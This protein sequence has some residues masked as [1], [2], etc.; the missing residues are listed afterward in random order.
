MATTD[1]P[2]RVSTASVSVD[3]VIQRVGKDIVL[4]LPLGL[5][6]PIHFTNAL[7]QRAMKD[8]SIQLHIVTALSLVPPK[9]KKGAATELEYRFKL[10]IIERLYADI[11]ELDYAR[12]VRDRALPDNVKVS[13]FFFQAGDFLHH[14]EQ[15]RRYICTNYTHALRDLQA[16]GINVV[17]QLLASPEAH[18]SEE[19]PAQFSL[20]CNPDLS[21]DLFRALRA[22]ETK[23]NPV[24]LVGEVNQ[25]LPFFGHD[26]ALPAETF[27]VVLQQPE[28]DYALFPVPQNAISAQDHLI[29]FYASTLLKDG[30]TLQVGIGSLGSALIYST[31]LRHQD[32]HAWQTLF[33]A[34]RVDERFPVVGRIGGNKPFKNGLYGCSEMMVDGFIYLLEAGILKRKVYP[35]AVLQEQINAGELEPQSDDDPRLQQ[36]V[37]MHGGFFLGP[38]RFYEKLNEL[39]DEQRQLICMTSVNFINNLTNHRF[40]DQRLKVA[41]RQHSRFINS[42][43]QCTLNGAVVS[44]GLED[45]RVL[46]GVGGQYN[47]VS[48]AHELPGARS[49][50]TLRATRT[51]HGKTRSTI[52]FSYGH[53]TIPRHLRDIVIT[54]YGIAD[55]RGKNDEQVYLELIR[56]ADSRFQSDLLKQAQDAGKVAPDFRLPQDWQNNTP[57][58]VQGA[59]QALQTKGLFPAFPYGTELNDTERTLKPA[60]EY[61]QSLAATIRG[62]LKLLGQALLAGGARPADR[63]LLQRMQLE[64]PRSPASWFARRLLR[65]A[66]KHTGH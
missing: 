10:P 63:V 4:G 26:A 45:G 3:E 54:E 61:V 7:Y 31:C 62:K 22:A 43:M 5:G 38:A 46:S 50:I 29:G 18:P 8:P 33:R 65:A 56:I 2:R 51:S 32:N 24:A 37:V 57:Q 28:D 9:L 52:V 27:D 15:Q 36:G 35:D 42:A 58:A 17:A 12:D 53:C 34:L 20:S 41:Q 60:L 23:G 59:L 13:E 49:I 11:P 48:M 14:D 1:R 47:F 25:H 39:S 21:L 64:H 40:G 66:L 6:K 30:G 16:L 19:P 44:D 55:L